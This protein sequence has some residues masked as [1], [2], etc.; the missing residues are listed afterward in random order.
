MIKKLILGLSLVVSM[1]A[2]SAVTMEQF[3]TVCG[4]QVT[5]PIKSAEDFMCVGIGTALADSSVYLLAAFGKELP[6]GK[7]CKLSAEQLTNRVLRRYP[8][9][10]T[11]AIERFYE[12]ALRHIT[13]CSKGVSI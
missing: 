9:D 2:S 4:K 6:E 13:Q 12:E 10:S 1:S 3:R 5:S 7:A 11:N 8:S